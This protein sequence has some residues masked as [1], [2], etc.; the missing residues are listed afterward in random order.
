MKQ[1]IDICKSVFN[2]PLNAWKTNRT[3]VMTKGIIGAMFQH[4]MSEGFPLLTT[5]KMPIRLIAVEL[6]G[7]LRGITDK[8]WFQDRGCHIWDEWANPSKVPYDND[9]E[10]KAAMLAEPD[11]GPIYGAQWVGWGASTTGLTNQ[12]NQL[13]DLVETLK[14]DPFSRRL[15]VSAWNVAEL[16]QMAL[17]PCH[18]LWQVVVSGDNR[19]N[20]IWY[21][22][23]VDLAV[24]LP[25]NIASYGILLTLLAK[26]CGREPGLLTGMLSDVHIY[27]THYYDL[28]SQSLRAPLP[29]SSIKIPGFDSIFSWDHT[30]LKLENYQCHP[31][32][33]FDIVV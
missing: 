3:G 26:E 29:L 6:D 31:S 8:R 20:L 33:K 27:Q 9:P 30:K 11:L 4:D 2:A 15:L 25:F 1:Y 21:Q 7:F 16:D 22:R 17:P 14:V 28:V 12:Y 13:V 5:K 10:S 19:L 18:V 32:I 24:G 23:S